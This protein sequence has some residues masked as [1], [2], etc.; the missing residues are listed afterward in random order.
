MARTRLIVTALLT[1]ALM[2][3]GATVAASAY[4]AG[5]LTTAL[6]TTPGDANSYTGSFTITNGSSFAVRSWA[7]AFVLPAGSQIT[8]SSGARLSISGQQVTAVNN[9]NQGRIAPGGKATFNFAVN[10]STQPPTG[11]TVNGAPCAPTP[12]PTP[13]P[14]SGPAPTDSPTG[15]PKPT[16]PPA[17]TTPP[18]TAPAPSPTSSP[19]PNPPKAPT[20]SPTAPAA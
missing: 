1:L 9:V 13:T 11:C 17:T 19:S 5:G 4:A 14:T 10:G 6:T 15:Q 3:V 12:T 8:S 20:P 18:T 7:V 16:T 2:L